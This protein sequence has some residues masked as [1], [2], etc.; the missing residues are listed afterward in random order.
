LTERPHRRCT[1][2]VQ[3]YLLGC[4]IVHL[5][6]PPTRVHIPNDISIDS[7][8][9]AQLSAESPY[10]LQWAAPSLS[11][12]PLPM[13]DVDSRLIHASTGQ[14]ESIPKGHRHRFRGFCIGL[15]VMTDRQTDHGTPSVTIGRICVRSKPTAMRPKNNTHTDLQKLQ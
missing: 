9:F 14:L 3:S 8:V 1:R 10:T 4:A 2:T 6:P 13:G 7:A 11:K 5:G 12:L 15:T